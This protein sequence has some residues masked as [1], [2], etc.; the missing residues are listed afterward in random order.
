MCF[1]D[2]DA[3]ISQGSAHTAGENNETI[4]ILFYRLPLNI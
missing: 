4:D 2:A 1:A 3:W